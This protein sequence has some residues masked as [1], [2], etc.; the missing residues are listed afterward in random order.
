MSKLFCCDVVVKCHRNLS[1]E[2]IELR[3][4]QEKM[5]GFDEKYL[6]STSNK[7]LLQQC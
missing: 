1:F 2:K 5:M 6:W 3:L 7:I 4:T